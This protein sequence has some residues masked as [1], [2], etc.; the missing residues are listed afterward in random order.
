VGL[1]EEKLE[2]LRSWGEA[3]RQAPSEEH[4][5]VGRAIVMLAE[6]IDELNIALWHARLRLGGMASA[7]ADAPEETE[8]PMGRTLHQR[9]Q[10]ALGRDSGASD[11]R[12]P[13]AAQ[14]WIAALRRRK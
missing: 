2:A 9:L 1:D 3:L 8:E 11:D 10:G 12:S 14:S 5:A 4:A 13:T 6:E 7:P